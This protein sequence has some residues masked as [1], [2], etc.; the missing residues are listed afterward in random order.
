MIIGDSDFRDPPAQARI[1]I[2]G[3]GD[4]GSNNAVGVKAAAVSLSPYVPFSPGGIAGGYVFRGPNTPLTGSYV[5]DTIS[6]RFFAGTHA[7][8]FD[9]L[10]QG[11]TIVGAGLTGGLGVSASIVSFGEDADRSIYIVS[12]PRVYKMVWR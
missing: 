12:P 3:P 9:R 8:P 7:V 1:L 10:Q 6:T 4:A 2:L 5:F 11:P